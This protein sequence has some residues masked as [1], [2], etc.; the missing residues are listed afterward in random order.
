MAMDTVDALELDIRTRA[1]DASQEI[2]SL[3]GSVD[4]FGKKVSAHLT[5]LKG[6]ADVLE[7]ISSAMKSVGATRNMQSVA[8]NIANAAKAAK[9]Q[10]AAQIS[11]AT[12][13]AEK[14]SGEAAVRALVKPT[15]RGP[16]SGPGI[17]QYNPAT[18]KFEPTQFASSREWF[19]S[20]DAARAEAERQGKASEIEALRNEFGGSS[21]KV[22]SVIANNH[23]MSVEELFP[24]QEEISAAAS[25][26]EKLGDEMRTVADEAKDASK[27]TKEVK[28]ETEESD[29]QAKK[30]HF[31]LSNIKGALAGVRD[32]LKHGILG[33][34]ERIARMRAL[35]Y[36]VKS[37][38]SALKEG[39][40]NLYQWSKMTNGHF[41]ASM[42]TAATKL[43]L[44]KNSIATALSPAIEALIPLLST[45]AGW[46]NTVANGI[47]QFFALLTGKDT[48]TKAT[49]ATQEWAA[50]TKTGT[51]NAKDANK[52]MKDLLADWDELNII[53]SK[54]NDTGSSGGSGSGKKAP[55]YKDMFEEMKVFD[56]WTKDFEEI[57]DLVY[58]IGGGI[59]GWFALNGIENFLS[60]MGLVDD[61]VTG[62]LNRFR[63]GIF[64]AI[65]LGISFTFADDIGE[66]IAQNGLTLDNALLGIADLIA[67]G[68][69]GHLVMNSIIPGTGMLG[70]IAGVT[71]AFAIGLT[72]YIR[73]RRNLTYAAMAHKAFAATGAGGI[74]L[75][76]YKAAL[77]SELER[78]IGDL[79]VSVNTFVK[80]G[81]AKEKLDAARTSI[82]NLLEYVTGG[83][84]LTKEEAEDFRK[85]WDIVKQA[86][87]DMH[88]ATW[89]T[90]NIGIAEAMKTESEE[91]RKYLKELQAQMLELQRLT[92]GAQAAWQEEVRQISGRISTG[93]ATDEDIRRY[94]VLLEL[95]GDSDT[96][97]SLRAMKEWKSTVEGFDFGKGEEA[98][99][100]ATNFIGEMDGVY[101]DAETEVKKWG[102]TQAEAVEA[103]RKELEAYNKAGFLTDEQYRQ[104]TETLDKW[105]TA[106]KNKVTKDLEE[107][108][109]LKDET[110]S[111]IFGQ[112]VSGYVANQASGGNGTEYVVQTAG[113]I[114]AL[115]AAGFEIP[116]T[117]DW[118]N[119]KQND[120][121]A[122]IKEGM[123]DTWDFLGGKDRFANMPVEAKYAAGMGYTNT[124]DSGPKFFKV[125]GPE[126]I[127]G[128]STAKGS[129]EMK[130]N[131]W[132][133]TPDSPVTV[134]LTAAKEAKV[135]VEG[136]K[137]I[138]LP[139][140]VIDE[141]AGKD[142]RIKTDSNGNW[143]WTPNN[144]VTIDLT[145][146]KKP[147]VHF[148]GD[149][150]KLSDSIIKEFAGKDGKF[151]TDSN[152]NWMWTPDNPV[153]VDLR[154]DTDD[155]SIAETEQNTRTY[156][157]YDDPDTDDWSMADLYQEEHAPIQEWW[158]TVRD[159]SRW[160]EEEAAYRK[161]EEFFGSDLAQEIA[162]AAIQFA[163]NGNWWNKEDLP[164]DVYESLLTNI[165]GKVVPEEGM[166]INTAAS[167]IATEATMKNLENVSHE[168]STKISGSLPSIISVLGRIADSSQRAADKDFT[169]TVTPSA[170][171]G[172]Q[173]A[174]SGM[175]YNMLTGG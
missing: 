13:D 15:P 147:K 96:S 21:D 73:K 42:D 127:K 150:V 61:K 95:L 9:G 69:G 74:E 18:G 49:E 113:I 77:E 75:D 33:Q 138:N 97:E 144:P 122:R 78:K 79:T 8:K 29:K 82:S 57:R 157:P 160:D 142:G 134:S 103:A 46:V 115:Q 14:K 27:A 149:G 105:T 40:D 140:S 99:E 88:N 171:W 24:K 64:G 128:I 2:A 110:Y 37:V 163:E 114:K 26:A 109:R 35:R 158:D 167:G 89:D 126:E 153:T 94:G 54:N 125:A 20:L 161:M 137:G 53:Q 112:V 80:Y 72:A 120:F 92:G 5:D 100:N 58:L 50:A 102:E 170:A 17:K 101:S 154:A 56:E 151:I 67:A 168:D 159:Q 131:E 7:R 132:T 84:K 148:T 135:E 155:W 34:L 68:V 16:S 145:V 107:I 143:T 121:F 174:R 63:R 38:A 169:V 87:S 86:I 43:M 60:A 123:E 31:D 30:L 4:A 76:K 6:L 165:F 19:Q 146:D 139:D 166:T 116:D 32:G 156:I 119:P 175:M 62:I 81:E 47:S 152:G 1:K 51:K 12:E 66:S 25:E 106:Y 59:A 117:Y 108:K 98:V 36:I 141:F 3:A 111:T 172:R 118:L 83:R 124:S 55:N 70:T 91:G 44:I 22:K 11:K 71:I 65:L 104:G 136:G 45:V 52:E 28:K 39:L 162:N 93:T 23:G 129:I 90:I 173:A 41:A 10:V 164:T 85:N 133:W 48:W 130:G